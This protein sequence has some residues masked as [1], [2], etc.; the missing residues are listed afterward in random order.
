MLLIGLITER[1]EIKQVRGLGAQ[2]EIS[3]PKP[4]GKIKAIQEVGELT[5][6]VARFSKVPK[7]FQ[8]LKA[9]P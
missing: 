3:Y 9:V 7:P 2:R 8:S 1:Q 6:S 4:L 5:G